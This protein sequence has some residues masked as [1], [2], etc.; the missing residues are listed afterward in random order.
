MILWESY[1]LIPSLLPELFLS[2]SE[3]AKR[4]TICDLIGEKDKAEGADM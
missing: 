3:A 1:P 4:A 2:L